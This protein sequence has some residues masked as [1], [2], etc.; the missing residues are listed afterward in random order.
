MK[1]E[2]AENDLHT[3][4]AKNIFLEEKFRLLEDANQF[5]EMKLVEFQQNNTEVMEENII[6]KKQIVE[7]SLAMEELQ[8]DLEIL[9]E[10]VE[11]KSQAQETRLSKIDGFVDEKSV[12]AQENYRLIENLGILKKKMNTIL[13][14]N[15]SL[16][17]H[18]NAYA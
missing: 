3:L 1:L 13:L 16:R 8:R 7:F 17:E 4:R 10:E 18:V 12:L 5:M 14:D 9:K 11:L 15:R 2:E 6:I